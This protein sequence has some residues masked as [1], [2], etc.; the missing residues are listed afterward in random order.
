MIALDL[1]DMDVS[2]LK[3]ASK[4]C[5]II[6]AEKVYFINIQGNLDLDDEMRELLMGENKMPLDEYVIEKMK[7]VVATNFKTN[8]AVEIEYD[9]VE[10]N[11]SN[12][13]LRWVKMKDADLLVLGRKKTMGG[14]GIMPQQIALKVKS[15]VLIVPEGDVSFSLDHVFL[16]LDFSE[17]SKKSLEEAYDIDEN[18]PVKVKVSA[19]HFYEF[20]LGFEKSGKT[21][22]EFGAILERNAVKRFNNFKED[23]GGRAMELQPQIIRVERNSSVAETINIEAHKVNANMIIIGA[24]GRTLATQLFMGS[25][26]QKLIKETSDIPLLIVKDKKNTF[27]FWDFMK[28][29]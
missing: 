15:S 16:P 20:P 6:K 14:S 12:E 2:I 27:D 18:H 21:E 26:T 17:L 7:D 29:V 1:T 22:D 4:M 13:M 11:V 9:V 3:Y 10:G 23:V 5:D 19:A 24:K 8:N 25:V 28:S